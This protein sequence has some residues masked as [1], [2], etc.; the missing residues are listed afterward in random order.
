MWADCI[1]FWVSYGSTEI[2]IFRL[3]SINVELSLYNITINMLK[4]SWGS[5]PL[6]IKHNIYSR[7]DKHV[8]DMWTGYTLQITGIMV[9]TLLYLVLL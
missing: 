1:N 9:K 4:Y 5:K 2:I 8:Q 3:L 6:A 7:I